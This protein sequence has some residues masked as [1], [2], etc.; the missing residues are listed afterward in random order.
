M[1]KLKPWL[2]GVCSFVVVALGTTVALH[3]GHGDFDPC[4]ALASRLVARSFGHDLERLERGA[5]VPSDSAK[6]VGALRASMV[7]WT[8]DL[9]H[10][11]DGG[12]ACLLSLAGLGQT[13][14]DR[15]T[16][17]LLQERSCQLQREQG[18]PTSTT[19]AALEAGR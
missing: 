14:M 12:V 6:A 13:S 17:K 3:L 7:R 18:L 16:G 2:A 5:D 4:E 19:C 1:Q 8:A 10:R 9:L 15:V 11:H